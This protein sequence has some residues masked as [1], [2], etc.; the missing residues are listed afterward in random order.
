MKPGELPLILLSGGVVFTKFLS[1][2]RVEIPRA[3]GLLCAAGVILCLASASSAQ[4]DRAGLSGTVSDPSGRALVQ[5]HITAVHNDTGLR[6]ET[7]SSALGTYDIPELP[8]GVYTVTFVHEGFK[9]LTFENVVQGVEHTRTLNATMPVSGGKVRIEVSTSSEQ[10][11]Q[12]SDAL[13]GRTERTQVEELPLNGRNWANL[14]ALVPGAV[15]TGGS[16]QRSVR[17]AG[18]GRDDNDFTYD[19][20]DA[21]NIINQGSRHTCAWRFPSIPFRS[22]A[23]TR[24]WRPQREEEPEADNYP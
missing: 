9:D 16:N 20:I 23:S 22:F 18:R 13:G 4:V 2:I 24:H 19:G 21:T 10:L 8:I 17:F 5:T 1:G 14:T 7:T 15:D 11:D 12:T 6:R 3:A